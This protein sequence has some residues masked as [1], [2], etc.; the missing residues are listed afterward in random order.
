[1]LSN[2]IINQGLVTFEDPSGAVSNEWTD[3]AIAEIAAEGTSFF[4]GTTWNG[5]RAMR[6]SVSNWQISQE[7]VTKTVAGVERVL[8]GMLDSN[9]WRRGQGKPDLFGRRRGHRR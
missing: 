8:A 7:D 3:K 1:M 9:A 4:S 2:P 6:I 5:R